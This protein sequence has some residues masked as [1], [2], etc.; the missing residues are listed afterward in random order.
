MGCV[1][2]SSGLFPYL[3]INDNGVELS[4]VQQ[5]NR[6]WPVLTVKCTPHTRFVKTANRALV[7]DSYHAHWS[8]ARAG[9]AVIRS[10]SAA[11]S[12]AKGLLK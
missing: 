3:Q 11:C 2:N 4:A 9:T 8:A 5:A 10:L 7:L 1:Q 12:G 6:C